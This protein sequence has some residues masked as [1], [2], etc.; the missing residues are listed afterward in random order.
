M[1]GVRP[2]RSVTYRPTGACIGTAVYRPIHDPVWSIK[3]GKVFFEH[4]QNFLKRLE[5]CFACCLLTSGQFHT[6]VHVYSYVEA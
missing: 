3:R 2:S 6:R 5:L 4:N 1:T